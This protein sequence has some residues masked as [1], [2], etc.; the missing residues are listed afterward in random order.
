M[1]YMSS[2]L[3]GKGIGDALGAPFEQPHSATEPP[4]RLTGWEGD[5]LDTHG[6]YGDFKAGQWTDDTGKAVALAEAL[7]EGKG[8]IPKIVMEKYYSWYLAVPK[9]LVGGTIK[10]ALNRY[11]LWRDGP[12]ECG[13][14]GSEGNGSAMSCAAIG[15]YYRRDPL[16]AMEVAREEAMLTHNSLE[17][18]EG[19]AAIAGMIAQMSL[20]AAGDPSRFVDHLHIYKS[21]RASQMQSLLEEMVANLESGDISVAELVAEI[22]TKGHVLQTVPSAMACFLGTS[23][24][25]EAILTAIRAGGDADTTAAITGALAGAWYGYEG[26]PE[27]YKKGV[28]RGDYLHSLDLRLYNEGY[29]P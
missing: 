14:E 10:R 6:L 9:L 13:V 7:L 4:E 23:T 28:D 26:I 3:L 19:S 18:M 29:N 20:L 11:A 5:F 8:F 27:K 15:L 1:M 24:Y 21:L 22:G 2:P 17:A 25:E 12:S 16:K